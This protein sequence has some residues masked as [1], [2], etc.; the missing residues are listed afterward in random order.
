MITI[1]YILVTA[2]FIYFVL[3]C[4]IN[5]LLI[6]M[7]ATKVH[8]YNSKVAEGDFDHISKSRVALPVSLIIPAHNEEAIIVGTVE[9][10]L[11]LD[12]PVHEVIVV[13]DGS[14]DETIERLRKRFNLEPVERH[15]ASEIKTHKVHAVYESHDHPKLLVVSK[16]NGRR[17]DA[18]NVGANLSRY[19]LSIN[20]RSVVILLYFLNL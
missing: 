6:V 13:D 20:I 14:S 11:N 15:K 18:I 17:A 19:P 2:I 1:L 8:D 12:Y 16:E 5:L 10:T 7:G 9:N 3:L 4:A